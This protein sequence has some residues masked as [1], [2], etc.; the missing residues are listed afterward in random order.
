MS[1]E[2]PDEGIKLEEVEREL[3]INALKKSGQNQTRAADLL[4]ITRNTL[5]YRLEKYNIK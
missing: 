3:I 2:I 5:I 4:G 1:L